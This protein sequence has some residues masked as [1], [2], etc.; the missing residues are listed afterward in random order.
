MGVLRQQKLNFLCRLP[1]WE[2]TSGVQHACVALCTFYKFTFYK[3]YI[4]PRAT[5]LIFEL[6]GYVYGVNL[7][8]LS[9]ITKKTSGCAQPT[10]TP[11]SREPDVS[12]VLCG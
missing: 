10:D 5:I 1:H 6:A 8:A 11:L 4:L 3:L 9:A 7:A 12:H 2:N